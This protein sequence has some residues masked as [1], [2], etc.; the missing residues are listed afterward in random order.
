MKNVGE[1]DTE[2]LVAVS[3]ESN[4]T[5]FI[6]MSHESCMR[7]RVKHGT[8]SDKRRLDRQRL[9]ITRHSQ[10]SRPTSLVTKCVLRLFG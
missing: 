9:R 10:W 6:C 4:D 3:V 2:Q 8:K 7:N 1:L 5:T